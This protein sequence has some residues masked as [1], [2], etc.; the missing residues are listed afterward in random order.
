M[1][2]K[3][4]DG[5]CILGFHSRF[6]HC[7]S[8]ANFIQKWDA[9]EGSDR[10]KSYEEWDPYKG[11]QKLQP[12]ID[13]IQNASRTIDK[14]APNPKLHDLSKCQT[15]IECD[16][17]KLDIRATKFTD[18]TSFIT[19]FTETKTIKHTYI[20]TWKDYLGTSEKLYNDELQT[21]L[22]LASFC[23]TDTLYPYN[24]NDY[25]HD[26]NKRY[27]TSISPNIYGLKDYQRRNTRIWYTKEE[28]TNYEFDEQLYNYQLENLHSQYQ[29][30]NTQAKEYDEAIDIL[31]NS[32]DILTRYHNYQEYI[33]QHNTT[34]EIVSALNPIDDFQRCTGNMYTSDD[35]D[36]GLSCVGVATTFIPIGRLSKLSKISKVANISDKGAGVVKMGGKIDE[37]VKAGKVVKKA[38]QNGQVLTNAGNSSFW[39]STKSFRGKTRTNGESGNAKKYYEWDHTHK[40]IEVYNKNG[41]HLGSIDPVTG[42]QT[43]PAVLGRKINLK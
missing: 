16:T 42:Q 22:L 38:G 11:T 18:P 37:S 30:L 23:H 3:E 43:K 40:D 12:E 27:D 34:K 13:K 28:I 5:Y 2:N 21:Q 10:E 9:P 7:G 41:N 8:N 31:K 15:S 26:L 1:S 6:G 4:W 36:K 33:N 29:A 20:P 14:H 32:H 24:C 17:Q 25:H 39:R 19:S 35:W